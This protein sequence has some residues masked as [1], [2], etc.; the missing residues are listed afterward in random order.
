MTAARRPSPKSRR[1]RRWSP[2]A[3]WAVAFLGLAVWVGSRLE[4]FSVW[5]TVQLPDGS[6]VRLPDT[7]GTVDH[8]FHIVRAETLRRTLLDG[9]LL[10]W[11]GHY[12][13]G[14]PVEFYPLGAAG[15]EVGLWAV[16]LGSLPVGAVHKLAV[17]LIF[18]LPG[19][20]YLLMARRDRLSPGV[21]LVALAGQV[22]VRGWWW[23]GGSMELIEW[24]LVTNVA[25]ATAALLTLPLL[26]SYVQTGRGRDGAGAAAL[27]AFAV[28]ANPRS[29]IALAAVA[30]GAGAAALARSGVPRDVRR[31]A[32]RLGAVAGIAALVA[33][34]ELFSLLRFDALYYFVRYERYEN[35]GAYGRS[36]IQAVS[37]PFFIVALAGLALAF[38]VP[39]RVQSRA[40][41]FA[42][43]A[44]V[45]ATAVAAGASD[46]GFAG[47]LEATRLMPF[48]RF[49]MLY[50]AAFAVGE[51]VALLRRAARGEAWLP[52]VALGVVAALI[53]VAYVIRPLSVIPEGDRGL[54]TPASAATTAVAD[55]RESVQ[56]ADEEALP[57]SAIL[58]LGSPLDSPLTWHTQLWAPLW[59]DRPL[60]YDDWLWYWQAEHAGPYDPF[61][62]HAYDAERMAE[63]LDPDFLTRHGIGAV[64]IA[65]TPRTQLAAIAAESAPNLTPI[66]DGIFDVYLVRDARTIVS[67]GDRNAREVE[68]GNGE[69]RATVESAGGVATIRLNWFPRWRASVNGEPVPIAH[70]PDGYMDVAVPAGTADIRLTYVVDA[71]DWLARACCVLGAALIVWLLAG[72]PRPGR[73]AKPT[74]RSAL[75]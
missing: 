64:V 23:S 22:A 16:L 71:W 9:G 7:Y 53:L 39:H 35:L 27:A 6:T 60:F 38:A 42:L 1:L 66:R 37:G 54:V 75:R 25:G 58:V 12:Q 19:L 49:L 50:L 47:Q 40:A 46:G 55:L 3:I 56:L 18:L 13:G 67:V 5:Q 52:D 57:G 30:I 8:P 33:A 11:I 72:A 15:F 2:A 48:Q 32:V 21:A 59:S 73:V 44:Y 34:P 26:T 28:Y 61:V 29:S 17:W 36:S 68:V 45:G 10:R 63:T 62:E 65:E 43:V 24:G 31:T 51:A 41:A 69:L 20:A 4:V 74:E 14:Y 70:R